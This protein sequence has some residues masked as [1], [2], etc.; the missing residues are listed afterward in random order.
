MKKFMPVV[1]LIALLYGCSN[2]K[3]ICADHASGKMSTVETAGK[4]GIK[5]QYESDKKILRTRQLMCSS[6]N[7]SDEFITLD[8]STRQSVENY[9]E[10]YKR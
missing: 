3:D 2:R 7:P 6:C 4:F 10:Y 9:C 5:V 8:N 1:F